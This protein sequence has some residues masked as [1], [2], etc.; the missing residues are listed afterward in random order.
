[1]DTAETNLR[2]NDRKNASF[3]SILTHCWTADFLKTGYRRELNISDLLEPLDDDKS[4]ALG[5][6]LQR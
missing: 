5:N 3:L 2:K 1:M 6:R 4:E